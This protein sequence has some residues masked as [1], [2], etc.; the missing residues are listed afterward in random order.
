MEWLW[1]A[2][3]VLAACGLVTAARLWSLARKVEHLEQHME[4]LTQ[5]QAQLANQLG[6][7][8]HRNQLMR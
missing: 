2:T 3:G 8:W 1:T 4:F 5:Q 6:D 7:R